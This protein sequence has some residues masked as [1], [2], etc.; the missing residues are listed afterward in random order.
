[1]RTLLHCDK[2]RRLWNGLSADCDLALNICPKAFGL[3]NIGE[4]WKNLHVS[5]LAVAESQR[6][7]MAVATAMMKDDPEK[8]L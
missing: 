2:T 1:M 4:W 5:T 6:S 3:A 8:Y 7:V